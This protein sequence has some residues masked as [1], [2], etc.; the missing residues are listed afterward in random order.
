MGIASPPGWDASS[1]QVAHPVFCQ[2]SLTVLLKR[3]SISSDN[4]VVMI[5]VSKIVF[6]FYVV[7]ATYQDIKVFYCVTL[8]T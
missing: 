6:L 4:I 5:F 3:T 7:S 1:S 2:V 8:E